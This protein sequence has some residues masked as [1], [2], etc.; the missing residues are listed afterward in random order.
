MTPTIIPDK[1]YILHAIDVVL[2]ECIK[3]Q[4][5]SPDV[6]VGQEILGL[7]NA[8]AAVEQEWPLSD[9][10]KAKLNIGPVAA[11][12]IADWNDNLATALMVLHHVLKHDGDMLYRLLGPPPA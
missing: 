2:H 10:M 4:L 1:M 9:A 8:R 11:K 3:S 7:Q 5:T 6:A 12:N